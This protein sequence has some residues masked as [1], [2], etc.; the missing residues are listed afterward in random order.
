[1]QASKDSKQQKQQRRNA[2][3]AEDVEIA[4]SDV[5]KWCPSPKTYGC[6]QKSGDSEEHLNAELTIPNQ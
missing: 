4:H 2:G 3:K 1:M 5:R 6:N